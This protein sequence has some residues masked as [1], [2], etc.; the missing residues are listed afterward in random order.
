M[1]VIT[2]P[3]IHKAMIV[4]ENRVNGRQVLE[5]CRCLFRAKLNNIRTA[6]LPTLFLDRFT[7]GNNY[8]YTITFHLHT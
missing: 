1:F 5:R 3:I 2:P 7:I 4:H 6:K 8:Y